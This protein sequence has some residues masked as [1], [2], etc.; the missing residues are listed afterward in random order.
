M[1]YQF[2]T[3]DVFTDRMFGGNPLAVFSDARGLDD[4]TMQRIAREFNLSETVFV[5]PPDNPAHTRRLRIFTPAG[6]LQF[7]GHPTV[8]TA[9]VLAQVGALGPL[10]GERAAIVFEEG[11][12]PVP[13]TIFLRDGQ[14]T[15]AQ[16][17]AAKLPAAGQLPVAAADLAAMLGLDPAEIGYGDYG[18]EA[19]SSGGTPFTIIPLRDRAALARARVRLELWERHL[20][21][22]WAPEVYPIC[23]DPELPGSDLRVR[24]FAP[25]LGIAE[26]PATGAAATAL[27]GYLAPRAGLVD[28]TLRWVLEQGFEMGRPSI[29]EVEA[30]MAGGQLR[31]VRVGGAAVMVSE[32]RFEAPEG[33]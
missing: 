23:F 24:M 25:S 16:L 20:A 30:D 33:K 22:S 17:T 5:L 19:V 26:D 3:A 18:P 13:V 28:G 21:G 11:V 6:E 2:Y 27:A 31:A 8:G 9:F 1:R 10:E 29:L 7:A 15:G 4:A 32:G 14:P 12:G